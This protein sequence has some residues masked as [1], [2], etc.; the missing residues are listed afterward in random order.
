MEPAF[1]LKLSTL[2]ADQPTLAKQPRA[3]TRRRGRDRAASINKTV[4]ALP[5]SQRIRDREHVK[6]V[7]NQPCLVCG[8][9]PADAHH[10]RFAQHRRS[11]EGQ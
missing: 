9:R 3:L 4:F 1:Q 5:V 10:L 6:S 11:S 8:R 7:T 2:V